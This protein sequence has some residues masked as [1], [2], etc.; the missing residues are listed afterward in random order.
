MSPGTD[1]TGAA[2]HLRPQC[3]V[4]RRTFV[5][6]AAGLIGFCVS[7]V[8]QTDRETIAR[9]QLEKTGA[10]NV[11]PALSLARPDLFHGVDSTSLVRGL[12]VMTL[13]DGRPFATSTELS[14]MGVSALNVLPVAYLHTVDVHKVGASP[15][16]GT[17]GPGGVVNLRTNPIY[18]GGEVGVFYGR[19]TGKYGREDYGAHIIGGLGT[20][21][22]NITVGASYHESTIRLPRR[23]FPD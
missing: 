20:D 11:G 17:E 8:A 23:R 18:T 10:V 6:A 4:I 1:F 21:K 14:W 5:L 12:P 7:A 16:F 9:A 19:S 15:R 13:V 2:R 22:F 3:R